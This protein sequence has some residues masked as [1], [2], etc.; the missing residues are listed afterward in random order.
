[1]GLK[2]QVGD[3]IVTE[4]DK[5][6]DGMEVEIWGFGAILPRWVKSRSFTD[7]DRAIVGWFCRKGRIFRGI[8]RIDRV[9]PATNTLY[10]VGIL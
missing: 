3:F 10:F 7:M 1:M 9:E 8:V 5:L 6:A 2:A 4:S